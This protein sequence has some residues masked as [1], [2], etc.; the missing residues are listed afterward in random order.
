MARIHVTDDGW[1]KV[2]KKFGGK[3]ATGVWDIA[4]GGRKRTT[5]VDVTYFFIIE[6]GDIWKANDLFFDLKEFREL[7]VVVIPPKRDRRGR[8]FGFSRF[9]NVA[10]EKLLAINLDSIVLEDRKLF[11]NLPRF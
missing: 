2:T 3:R 4:G 7:V 1:S 6:F 5:K 10:G 11:A 9:S 8:G